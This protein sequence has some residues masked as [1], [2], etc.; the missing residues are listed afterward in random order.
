[1]G[2][3]GL[4]W[5]CRIPTLKGKAQTENPR[6]QSRA[7]LGQGEAWKDLR[8]SAQEARWREG[9]WEERVEGGTKAGETF[10]ERK[11][12]SVAIA[13]TNQEEEF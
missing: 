2:G 10:H 9:G 3:E 5:D 6:G 7:S 12:G 1:M 8:R 4:D 11:V 13:F